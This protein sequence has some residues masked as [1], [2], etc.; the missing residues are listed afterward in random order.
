M[1]AHSTITGFGLAAAAFVAAAAMASETV[2]PEPDGSTYH[3]VAHYA[4][5]VEAPATAVWDQLVDIGSWMHEFELTHESGAPG[6]EGEVRRLYSGQDFFIEI[7][8]IIPHE[9]LV[10]ANLPTTFNGEHSTGVAVITLTETVG[11]TTVKLTMSRGYSWDG[12]E[13]NPQKA[14]R[15]SPEFHER[16]RAQWQDRFLGRLRALVEEREPG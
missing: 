7:T 10:F 9:L 6:Q 2:T 16:T 14:T 4:V 5:D 13:P 12:T 1:V 3:F 11:T 8:K 15:E